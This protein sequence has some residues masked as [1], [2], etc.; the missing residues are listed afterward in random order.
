[1]T[2]YEL[3][4]WMVIVHYAENLNAQLSLY[5]YTDE[6][7]TFSDTVN[8]KRQRFPGHFQKLISNVEL[9]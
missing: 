6:K 7:K 8:F 5:V 2:R 4:G 9:H 1:M 3:C